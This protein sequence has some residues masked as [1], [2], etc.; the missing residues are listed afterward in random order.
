MFVC[1]NICVS[2]CV[3]VSVLESA[4]KANH[5]EHTSKQ[6]AS[7]ASVLAPASRFLA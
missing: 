6:H 4:D 3:S 5:E 7:M 2:V 1:I